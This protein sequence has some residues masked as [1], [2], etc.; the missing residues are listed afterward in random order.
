MAVILEHSPD[1]VKPLA[2]A[3][4]PALFKIVSAGRSILTVCSLSR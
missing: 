3:C 2:A 4:I 1:N